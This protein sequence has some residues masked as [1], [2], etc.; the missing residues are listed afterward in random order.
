M[1][2]TKVKILIYKGRDR[3]PASH[4]VRRYACTFSGNKYASK[5][6]HPIEVK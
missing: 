6:N 4:T 2:I 3:K 5:G 1:R